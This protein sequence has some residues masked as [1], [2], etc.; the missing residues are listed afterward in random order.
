M[1]TNKYEFDCLSVSEVTMHV[2]PKTETTKILATAQIVL[3]DQLSIRRIRVMNGTCGLYV[4]Y[5]VDP[6]YKGEDFRSI[7]TPITRQ[8][9]EHIENKILEKYQEAISNKEGSEDEDE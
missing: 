5:P 4:S 9:R 6:F 3:N 1:K 7:C 8:L 2:F